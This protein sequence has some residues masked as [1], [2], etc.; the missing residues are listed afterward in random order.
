MSFWQEISHLAS[1][2]VI[3][4]LELVHNREMALNREN[5]IIPHLES[6]INSSVQ[7]IEDSPPT[8][9]VNMCNMHRVYVY[10]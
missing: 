7:V 8:A 1:S 10:V 2:A 3:W 4:T 9:A 5:I 6:L